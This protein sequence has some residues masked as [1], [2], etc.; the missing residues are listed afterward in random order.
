MLLI[1]KNELHQAME[2]VEEEFRS[3]KEHNEKELE[4][5]KGTPSHETME[6][7]Y[8][9]LHFGYECAIRHFKSVF[10][11]FIYPDFHNNEKVQEIKIDLESILNP[12]DGDDE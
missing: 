1:D 11:P 2:T 8:K 7:A 12:T 3:I 4:G 9:N 5:L 6:T 10:E